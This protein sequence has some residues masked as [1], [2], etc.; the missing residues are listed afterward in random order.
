MDK[1]IVNKL[2]FI[3][4]DLNELEMEIAKDFFDEINS[5]KADTNRSI[6]GGVFQSV[7]IGIRNLLAAR[8]K[9]EHKED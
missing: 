2:N 6:H 1:Q 9:I 8:Y 7:S 4:R 5:G 3:I